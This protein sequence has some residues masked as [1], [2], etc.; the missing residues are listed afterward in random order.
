MEG[1]LD[2]ISPQDSPAAID[3]A[4]AAASPVQP[5]AELPAT[6]SKVKQQLNEPD[7]EFFSRLPITQRTVSADVWANEMKSKR[8]VPFSR[9]S[10][11]PRG[12]GKMDRDLVI[13]GT[14]YQ[15]VA[16]DKLANGDTYSRWCL[17]DLA[18]PKPRHVV[19]HLRFKAYRH[20]LLPENAAKACR[21]A[22][23][24][25]LNPI[26]V[27]AG[28]VGPNDAAEPVV[29]VEQ[30][31]L[32]FKL[33]FCPA[34][35][36]CEVLRC[37]QP[38]NKFL[39]DHICPGHRNATYANKSCRIA[40]G[41]G[42]AV[43]VA[44]NKAEQAM[45]RRR[46]TR[47][48]SQQSGAAD[49]EDDAARE[50]AIAKRN[51]TS[52]DALRMKT[53]VALELDSRRFQHSEYTGSY[54]RSVVHGLPVQQAE[55]SRVPVMGRGLDESGD[56]HLDISTL[57]TDEKLKAQRMMRERQPLNSSRL[58]ATASDRRTPSSS[59]AAAKRP[60]AEAKAEAEAE[61][62]ALE[63]P[64]SKKQKV[65]TM[66]ELLEQL[67][68]RRLERRAGA[69]GRLARAEGLSRIDELEEGLISEPISQED[70][71]ALL[72][73]IEAAGTD[74]AKLCTVLEVAAKAAAV[75]GFAGSRLYEVV[76]TL[77]RSM[78]ED[79][80]AVRRLALT[81]RRKWRLAFNAASA[82]AAAAAVAQQGAELTSVPETEANPGPADAT[83][84]AP[85]QQC[86]E[87]TSVPEADDIPGP[88]DATDFV[89]NPSEE[90]IET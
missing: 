70:A 67:Q 1:Q 2:G 36:Q 18:E 55:T 90:V 56:L 51:A 69:N 80:A 81:A 43:G 32:V 21:G 26:L 5:R 37:V 42:A 58:A 66:T 35:G 46:P 38:C 29:R 47:R 78:E 59:S 34:L 52:G 23:F 33:G 82:A 88:A 54:I 40:A 30:G 64:A 61:A 31:A 60:R 17:V 49:E 41:G 7:M 68:T 79:R 83:D 62:E 84:F 57:E 63:K 73:D 8:F 85:D 39:G 4:E 53:T 89:E 86:A 11:L 10:D 20:W 77:G 6:D 15:V 19:V 25:V 74:V 12:S 65:P 3:H 13:I 44:A 22:I 16:S 27:D 14:V 24:A 87:L 50:A 76:G 75:D 72:I 28:R 71:E 9:L 45:L 48:G